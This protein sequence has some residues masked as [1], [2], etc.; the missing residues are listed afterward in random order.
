MPND[1][2]DLL[3]EPFI[4][5]PENRRIAAALRIHRPANDW[6]W[7]S[8]GC[9]HSGKHKKLCTECKTCYPCRT[10]TALTGED[11]HDAR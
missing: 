1:D 11:H 2:L 4:D 3:A 10:A 8:F 9:T 5:T 6:S 7:Q